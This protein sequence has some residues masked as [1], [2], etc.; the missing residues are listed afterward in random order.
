MI[1][2]LRGSYEIRW[3]D[4]LHIYEISPV[5]LSYKINDFFLRNIW[6]WWKSITA[7]YWNLLIPSTSHFLKINAWGVPKL[8]IKV[9]QVI[10]ISSTTQKSILSGIPDNSLVNNSNLLT[11]LLSHNA[12]FQKN[13]FLPTNTTLPY[14]SGKFHMRIFSKLQAD[15]RIL[16]YN[17]KTESLAYLGTVQIN[18][19][20]R[21]HSELLRARKLEFLK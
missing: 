15:I 4:Q 9:I 5:L 13:N 6:T 8:K 10:R 3:S 19:E 21:A 11:H 18:L 14:Q 20:G 7:S 17:Q 16:H 1:Q 12:N 2:K